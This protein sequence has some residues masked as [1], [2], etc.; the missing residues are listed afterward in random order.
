MNPFF[1]AAAEVQQACRDHGW[2]FCIVGG[3]AALRWGHP[4]YV[5]LTILTGR[6]PEQPVIDGLLGQFPARLDHARD[7]AIANRFILLEA[8]NG[9]PVNV[10]LGALEF[11]KR[12]VRRASA[13]DTEDGLVL[14]CSAEDLI[15]RKAFAGRDQD[16]ADVA[17]VISRQ[18]GSLDAGQILTELAPLL[19]LKGAWE[20]INRVRELLDA[21]H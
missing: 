20:N 17:G 15:V 3:L 14:T 9:V 13:W 1:S 16:W 7:F 11:E 21:A 6:G 10:A 18:R 4:L 19:E 5:D 2:S 12:A 8:S